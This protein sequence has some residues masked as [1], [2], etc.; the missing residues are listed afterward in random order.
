MR[1]ITSTTAKLLP[2]ALTMQLDLDPLYVGD[3]LVTITLEPVGDDKVRINTHAWDNPKV[4]LAHEA[5]EV[6]ALGKRLY[7]CRGERPAA[8]LN[9]DMTG[10]TD[11]GYGPVTK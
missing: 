11:A 8:Y 1:R 4:I 9:L 7:L 3:K 10:L 2:P 5:L 6:L